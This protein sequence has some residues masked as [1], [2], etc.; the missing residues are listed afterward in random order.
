MAF[1]WAVV[2]QSELNEIATLVRKLDLLACIEGL[3]ML[4]VPDFSKDKRSAA[5][6]EG[7][8]GTE[9]RCR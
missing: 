1:V 6:L 9:S 5:Q 7:Y 8:L 2:V 4:H 3:S